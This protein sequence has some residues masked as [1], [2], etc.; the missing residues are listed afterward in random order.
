VRSPSGNDP[1]PLHPVP[2]RVRPRVWNDLARVF[3]TVCNPFLTALALFVILAH[4]RARDTAN[5]WVLLGISAFFVSIG[6]MILIF[7]LYA[8]G[9]ISDLD[10]SIRAERARVFMAFVVFMLAGT[11]VLFAIHAPAIITATMAGYT[12][13]A[14]VIECITRFWKIST[15]GFGITAPIIVLSVIYG[16]QALPFIVLIPIVGWAR[17]Y[18]RAHT[19]LQVIA[20]IALGAASTGFFLRAFRVI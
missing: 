6:P 20:G 17:V 11:G 7:W 15:H 4:D 16:A 9:R 10:M 8:T 19:P 2:G 13:S 14:L 1:T 5:F 3:S 18:T 12:V